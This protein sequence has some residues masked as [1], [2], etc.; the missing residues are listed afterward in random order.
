MHGTN[1]ILD[2]TC[3]CGRMGHDACPVSGRGFQ[4]QA[5]PLM[6]RKNTMVGKGWEYIE[7][8]QDRDDHGG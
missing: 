4:K 8:Y 1:Y 7:A 2:D 6:P 3:L 5:G